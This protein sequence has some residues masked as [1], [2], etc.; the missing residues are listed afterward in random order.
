MLHEIQPE[1]NVIIDKFKGF[2][3]LA[4]NAFETQTLLQLKNEYC[5][6]KKCLSCGIGIRLLNSTQ[7]TKID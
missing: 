2:G 4:K 6:L 3:L 1:K 5:N 7:T